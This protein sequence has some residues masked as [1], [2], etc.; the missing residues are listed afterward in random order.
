MN[1]ELVLHETLLQ[2]KS[3]YS[4]LSLKLFLKKEKKCGIICVGV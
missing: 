3:V 4:E 2:K 1:L